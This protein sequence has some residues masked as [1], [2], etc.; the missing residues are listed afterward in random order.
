MTKL[1]DLAL[2]KFRKLP[3]DQ[4]D[5]IAHAILSLTENDKEAEPIDPAHLSA[6]VEGL[7]QAGRAEFAT[8]KEIE[9]AFR[10][11]EG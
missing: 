11:F 5:E 6:I 3:A 9:A 7:A 1:L 2:E 4:Q 8:D 10:R